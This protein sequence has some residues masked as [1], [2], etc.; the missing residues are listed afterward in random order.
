[1]GYEPAKRPRSAGW[2]ALNRYSSERRKLMTSMWPAER[3]QSVERLRV[4]REVLHAP[5]YAEA[6]LDAPIDEVWAVAGDLE[7]ELPHLLRT[8]RSFHLGE[9]RPDHIAAVAV[10]RLGYRTRFD[11]T[12]EPGWCLMQSRAVVGG[13]AATPEGTGTRFAVLGGGRGPFRR[14]RRAFFSPGGARLGRRILADLDRRVAH[15]AKRRG[16]E[17]S[18]PSN[19]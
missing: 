19:D 1:M 2:V 4:L 10:S 13:M 3:L 12:L 7:G 14:V 8:L 15:H 16:S 9:T 11:V 6:H 17:A 5:I 18:A